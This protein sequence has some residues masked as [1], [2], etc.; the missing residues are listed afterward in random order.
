MTQHHIWPQVPQ[1]HGRRTPWQCDPLA[2]VR[3]EQGVVW[4]GP[5][6]DA[7]VDLE[8]TEWLSN[9]DALQFSDAAAEIFEVVQPL[10][11]RGDVL[12]LGQAMHA[13][14]MAQCRRLA[15][16][17]LELDDLDRYDE[18]KAAQEAIK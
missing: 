16:R 9:I 8:A 4:Q 3:D 14:V 15:A 2:R 10:L 12:K 17:D 5:D 11:M 7:I 18:V 1:Y 13:A 6:L